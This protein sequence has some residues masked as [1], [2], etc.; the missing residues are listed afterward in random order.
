M[1]IKVLKPKEGINLYVWEITETTEEL[2]GL[3]GLS[4]RPNLDKLRNVDHI[5]QTLAKNLILNKLELLPSLYKNSSGKPFLNNGLHISIS[6]SGLWVVI[7][8]AKYP[9]GIDVERPRKKLLKV[10]SKFLNMKDAGALKIKEIKDL[11]WYWTAKESIYKLVDK[12]GLS[13]KNDIII[14]NLMKEKLIGEA[15]TEE[16]LSIDLIFQKL[17]G[18][19]L[20]CLSF[21]KNSN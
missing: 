14:K 13:P 19:S 15:K 9:I 7:A 6:H 3:N 10:A 18:D 4:N 21:Y 16:N 20:I 2:L 11:L 5:K 12:P 17:P 8:V 1:P